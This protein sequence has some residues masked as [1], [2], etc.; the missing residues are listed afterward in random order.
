[1]AL[2]KNIRNWW[3]IKTG[4][5]ENPLDGETPFWV[6]SFFFHLV[7]LVVLAVVFLLSRS[8]QKISM[9]AP[10]IT[11]DPVEEVMPTVDFNME[12]NEEIG[13]NEDEGFEASM[14]TAPDIADN[15]DVSEDY[16][17]VKQE[18]GEIEFSEYVPQPV[19]IETTRLP[20]RGN[21]G[22]ATTGADGAVDR[23]THEIL[24]SLEERKTLVVWMFDQ[25]ASL[26]RQRDEILSRFDKIYGELKQVEEEG[27][28][29]FADKGDEPLLTQVVAFGQR[30]NEMLKKPT[31][32]LD[33][34]K[35]A[36]RNV[37]ID[38]S[39]V[40]NVFS[41]VAAV[42][43]KHKHLRRVDR[44]TK[45]RERNVLIVVVSDETGDDFN[46]L[47]SAVEVCKENEI[48]VYVIGVPAP[49]GR[50]ETFVKYVD[51]DPQY[52]QSVQWLPVNQGPESLYPERIRINFSARYEEEQP[53]DSGFGPFALTRLCYESGGTYFTVHPNRNTNGRV[54]RRDTDEFT[55]YFATFFDS[56]LMRRYRPDYVSTQHYRAEVESNKARL[57][58]VQAARE[59]WLSPM[60]PP[61]FRFE[62]LDEA[63]F[64]NEVNRAQQ[65]A[66][67]LSSKINKLYEILKLGEGDRDNEVVL[68]WKAGFDLAMGRVLAV[69]IRAESYN[70]TLAMLKTKMNFE[71]PKNNV[72]VLR[73]ANVILT[74]SA[75]ERLAEKAKMYLN[76]VIEEHPG[77]PWALLAKKELETPIGWELAETYQAPPQPAQPRQVNNN[78]PNPNRQRPMRQ[79]PAPKK[80]RTPKL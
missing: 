10:P 72:W 54:R 41:A 4:Q 78:N 55:A 53:I 14:A 34:I 70:K 26:S 57:A 23:I 30:Y 21:A 62:K 50:K 19:A 65:P 44:K 25:S 27:G 36:V 58:L 52:D 80:K 75:S 22:F 29:Q 71:D 48:P 17:L 24:M 46:M 20:V 37:Q 64:V 56:E 38:N 3:R 51:P 60:A 7:L 1:M 5:D 79:Q 68:R 45:D 16:E 66:A 6:L 61:Q 31:V 40:E 69:K 76:R 59:S 39:G 47:D 42:A 67:L 11:D 15:I 63:R 13:A 28:K 43:D 18:F 8:D 2:R 9:I 33:E 32:E 12:D 49:F 74:G 35:E 73:P 77:T